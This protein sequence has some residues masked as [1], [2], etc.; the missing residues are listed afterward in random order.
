MDFHSFSTF[1]QAQPAFIDWRYLC[2]G[3]LPAQINT[4][5]QQS[6]FYQFT[7]NLLD[8]IC[9]LIASCFLPSWSGQYVNI[10]FFQYIEKWVEE[11]ITMHIMSIYV[12]YSH[13]DYQGLLSA[14]HPHT[15]HT[16]RRTVP[17]VEPPR[18]PDTHTHTRTSQMA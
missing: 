6:V 13:S 11:K 14:S 18:P 16:D 7:P 9:L 2:R 8:A 3:I 4:T 1:Y 17:S 5:R 12:L 10:T 15:T